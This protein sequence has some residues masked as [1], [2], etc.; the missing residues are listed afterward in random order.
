MTI[1][2]KTTSVE[3]IRNT[4]SAI[5][6]RFGDKPATRYQEASFDLEARA[7]FHYRPL[8]DPKRTLNDASRTSIRMEDWYAVTDP[9]QF[10][11]GAYVGNRAKMQEA[12]ESNFAFCDKRNLLTRLPEKT[13]HQLLRLLVPLRHVELGA[14]MNNSKIAGDAI[15][16]TVAQMHMFAATDRLGMG[17][18]LSRI[19]L[20][21]D[22]STGKA[23][24][25]SKTFWM[26]DE[27][28]QPMR[29]LVEDLLVIDDWFELTLVQ[30]VLLDGLMYP[31]IY[32]HMDAW[33]GEQGAED[34]SL[35]TE[36]QRDW[37]KES[38]RWTNSMIKTVGGENDGNRE[39]L[40]HWVTQW[41]H[42]VYEALMPI[43]QATTGLGA[44][45]ETRA[46]LSVRLKKA[47]LESTGVQA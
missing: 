24:D 33:L 26:D 41:E 42:R 43:A 22:G 1:E 37:Y 3:P 15:A 31:L 47:G 13:Q 7:N 32:D 35:L 30:N 20:L 34:V 8:W 12:A 39:Q 6:R 2:I 17:Q 9:R 44:L 38:Q 16:T 10:F 29:K 11:Y 25:E 14:N 21:L 23:L 5:A 46:E 28:W 45:D 18:Y 40:Q 36:F 27:L 4:Y 19:A